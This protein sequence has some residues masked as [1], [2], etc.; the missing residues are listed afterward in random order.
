MYRIAFLAWL[1]PTMPALAGS[2]PVSGTATIPAEPDEAHISARMVSHGASASAALATHK[3]QMQQLLKLLAK[4]GIDPKADVQP[5]DLRLV[6]EHTTYEYEW[7]DSSESHTVVSG[8]AV[9]QPFSVRLRDPAKTA[10]ALDV[11]AR[12]GVKEVSK[13][14]F[15]A[16][17]QDVLVDQA[18]KLAVK[19]AKRKAKLLA[20]AAGVQLVK[21]EQI[22]ESSDLYQVAYKP[23]E[24][25]K[26][27]VRTTMI[28]GFHIRVVVDIT[29][30][31]TEANNATAS[32][33]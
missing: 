25:R 6:P 22:R 15:R 11:M 32:R 28:E 26:V 10:A 27:A 13:V 2:L 33:R 30:Q 9:Y 4:Q 14:K 23:A 21:V 3:Q 19:D 24:P 7:Y 17:D 31:I 12:Q 8:Y 1:L 5:T 16:K 18:L 20:E 29:Y